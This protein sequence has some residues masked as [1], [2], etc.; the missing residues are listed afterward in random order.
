MRLEQLRSLTNTDKIDKEIGFDVTI[1]LESM[2]HKNKRQVVFT[3]YENTRD[4]DGTE[5]NLKT[6]H[7]YYCDVTSTH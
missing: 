2:C 6:V 5:Y 3:L 4:K 1:L 7:Y